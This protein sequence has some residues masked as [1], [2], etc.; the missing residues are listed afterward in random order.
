MPGA[1]NCQDR[2]RNSAL[3]R[4]LVEPVLHRVQSVRARRKLG[5]VLALALLGRVAPQPEPV[6]NSR[7]QQSLANQR[8]DDHSERHKENEIAV[9]KRRA[10]QRGQRN[11]QRRRQR[12]DA[13]YADERKKEGPLPGRS[14]IAARK[15]GAEPAWQI[16]RRKNP[17]KPGSDDDCDGEQDGKQRAVQRDR[18]NPIEQ[19]SNLQAGQEEDQSLEQIDDQ[20]PKED[21]LQPRRRRNEQRPVP[22]DEQSSGDRRQNARSSN[23]RGEQKRG[24]RR[25]Q[26]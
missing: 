5:R 1:Q 11:G 17:D 24:I 12:D 16:N 26:R 22:T 6:H 8:D 14:R 10:G 18:I 23:M 9:G 7:Q 21:S 4:K 19:R 3:G 15:R 25:E 13:A 2:G 20:I